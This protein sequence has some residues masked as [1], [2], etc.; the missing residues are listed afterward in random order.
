MSLR[1][2]EARTPILL[3]PVACI[4][5]PSERVRAAAS[6]TVAGGVRERE[7]VF[8][9]FASYADKVDRD[10]APLDL[11]ATQAIRD[12]CRED[13]RVS[14]IQTG[15]WTFHVPILFAMG[16]AW[17]DVQASRAAVPNG[18][19]GRPASPSSGPAGS[20]DKATQKPRGGRG[21]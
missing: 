3:G 20:H 6:P 17:V 1:A 5:C 11:A 14:S 15:T 18:T 16:D 9:M 19:C 10:S 12:P 8:A 13:L 7:Y 4:G 2:S 21:P